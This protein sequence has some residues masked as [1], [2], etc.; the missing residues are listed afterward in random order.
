[1]KNVFLIA[2]MAAGLLGQSALGKDGPL[3]TVCKEDIAKFCPDK[4]HSF[5]AVRTCLELKK[6]ELGEACKA[7]LENTGPGRRQGQGQGMGPG[8]GP[9][10]GMPPN[11]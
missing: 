4:P 11:N 7:V 5:R 1:M 6:N 3:K 8:M 10:M 2:I 9:G